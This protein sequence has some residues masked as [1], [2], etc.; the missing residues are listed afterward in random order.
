MYYMVGKA[1]RL[2]PIFNFLGCKFTQVEFFFTQ[3]SA[4]LSLNFTFELKSRYFLKNSNQEV[5]NL[6][7]ELFSS[8]KVL[9]D[10]SMNTL[11][12]VQSAEK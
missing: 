7:L 8:A 3:Y 12:T 2:K 10:D 6:F 9:I 4:V 11:L 5:R 1:S